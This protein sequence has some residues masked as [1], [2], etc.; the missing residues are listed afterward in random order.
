MLQFITHKSEKYSME[1]EVQMVIEGGCRWIQLRMDD[2]TDEEFRAAALEII[3]LC[4]EHDAFLIFD[5]RVD[6][7]RELEVHGVHLNKGDMTPREARELLGPGA[8][9]GVT[10]TSVDEILALKGL[11][12]DYATLVPYRDK[13]GG[14]GLGLEGYRD[15]VEKV[16]AAGMTIPI[17]AYGGVGSDDVEPLLATGLNGVAMS[18]K[19]VSAPDP[20]LYV[21]AIMEKLLG[22]KG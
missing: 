20:M 16:R 15:A 6:M 11:D 10:C 17:V 8:I 13:K 2:A 7:T 12:I 18:E 3:P 21:S 5:D 19:V 14:E 9:V 22:I 4:R 1:E